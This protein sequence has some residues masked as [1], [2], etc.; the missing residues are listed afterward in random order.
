MAT[1][2]IT[3]YLY[4]GVQDFL[5]LEDREKDE[6]MTEACPLIER[7]LGDMGYLSQFTRNGVQLFYDDRGAW[8]APG[9]W[10]HGGEEI[11]SAYGASHLCDGF[12]VDYDGYNF[13]ITNSK[14][15]SSNKGSWN[16]FDDLLMG[17]PKEYHVNVMYR[18]KMRA[19]M[20][21]ERYAYESRTK[22]QRKT[23]ERKL[24]TG[25]LMT[26]YYRFDHKMCWKRDKRRGYYPEVVTKFRSY[27]DGA[28]RYGVEAATTKQIGED[29][30]ELARGLSE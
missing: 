1:F 29:E 14:T 15:V 6:V 23:L 13:I 2:P 10:A 19:Q 20:G 24:I 25:N 28:I 30:Y 11:G 17:V 21:E 12:S 18:S 9:K 8:S 27:I 4:E 3:S 16:L 5:A 7:K 22:K 26:F